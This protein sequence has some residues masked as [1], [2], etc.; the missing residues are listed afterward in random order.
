MTKN[1][2]SGNK[3]KLG[4]WNLGRWGLPINFIAII[5]TTVT[6]IFS[7]FPVGVPVDQTTMNYSCVIYGGTLLLGTIYYFARGH[8][9][10]IG[11]STDLDVDE[12]MSR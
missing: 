3:M 11:P 10:Y 9:K 4:P 8:K 5:Y 6:I 12:Y 2:L 7:F 1:K